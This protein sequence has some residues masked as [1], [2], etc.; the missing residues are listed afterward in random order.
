VE[1]I[2]EYYWDF[3]LT[4]PLVELRNLANVAQLVIEC[5]TRRKESRG[6]HAN[7]DHPDRDD[8]RFGRDTLVRR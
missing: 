2:T 5:A 7:S 6:L 4:P 1:L 3:V 8:A